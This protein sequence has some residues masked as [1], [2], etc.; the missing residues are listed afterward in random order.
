MGVSRLSCCREWIILFRVRGI[1]SAPSSPPLVFR[2]ME[3]ANIDTT[4]SYIIYDGQC[5]VCSHYV[6]LL[7]L[8]DAIG[9]VELVNARDAHPL[10]QLVAASGY[11]L[12]EGLVFIHRGHTYFGEEGM[13]MMALLSSGS[14]LFNRLNGALFRRPWLTRVLYPVMK[15]GRRSLLWLLK[16]P[17]LAL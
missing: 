1:D 4:R 10:V 5:P 14:G 3:A 7:Q 9:V 17:P 16:R 12:N 2:V 8:R 6:R 15:V 11:D 13:T